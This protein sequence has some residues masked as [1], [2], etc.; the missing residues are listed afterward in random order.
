MSSGGG[1]WRRVVA[2]IAL[3]TDGFRLSALGSRVLL[4]P[5]GG[6]V[7][8]AESR[9]TIA[10]R[11]AGVVPQHPP[12]MRTPKSETNSPSICAIG[13]GSSGYTASPVPVLSGRPAFGIH[14]IGTAAWAV[15]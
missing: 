2:L 5:A 6:R 15:R 11:C 12:T 3:L 14:E 4:T 13:A 7:P 9:S 8:R 10:F 1:S